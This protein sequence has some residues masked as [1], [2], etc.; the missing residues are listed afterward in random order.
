[1]AWPKYAAGYEHQKHL[2]VR[3]VCK[4]KCN[5]TRFGRVSKHPW[6][7]RGL[8]KDPDLYVTCLKCKGQQ[9][10]VYNWDRL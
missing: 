10:D 3:Y 4:R 5:A 7:D 6:I 8:P 2:L 1:M 9:D